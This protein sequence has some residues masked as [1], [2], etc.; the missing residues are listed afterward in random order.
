MEAPV[1]PGWESIRMSRGRLGA[2]DLFDS[3]GEGTLYRVR[4]LLGP[5]RRPVLY[6]EYRPDTASEIDE[7]ALERFPLFARSL[8]PDTLQWLY[9]RAAWPA[10]IIT[11]DL[12]PS[13]TG[14]A[15][16]VIMPLAPPRFMA[17][18]RRSSGGTRLVP[19]KFELLLNGRNF[20][21]RVGIGISLS[22]RLQLLTSVAES[23]SF[24]HA[25]SIAVGDFSCK[26]LLF[27]INPRPSCYLIDCDSMAWNGHAAMP[28]G[29]TPEWEL[30]PGEPAAT[31]AAD[32]YKFALL[33]LRMHSGAQHHRS[34]SR[35]PD[36]TWSPLRRLVEV[37]LSCPPA[38]RPLITEWTGP[39]EAAAHAAPEEP[40]RSIPVSYYSARGARL[41]QLARG[42][43]AP[44]APRIGRIP[45][46]RQPQARPADPAAPRGPVTELA[47]TLLRRLLVRQTAN[48]SWVKLGAML[49]G[50]WAACAGA[51]GIAVAAG[52]NPR[53]MSHGA[54]FGLFAIFVV[55]AAG[56]FALATTEPR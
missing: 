12:P 28:L 22:Q 29:E 10:W 48:P 30:P 18:L 5:Y 13:G 54:E 37:A 3:G 41:P 9:R 19:A 46:L 50:L 14:R 16:G 39:L 15:T 43:H 51:F 32:V 20:L 47:V 31:T 7:N 26:N 55:F 42:L 33:V 4:G 40:E 38:D 8:A 44:D 52:L 24:L 45:G 17:E 25:H 11:D 1:A 49:V 36:S 56:A 53:H 34:A 27:S 35:L 21:D 6:K 23:L 2:L